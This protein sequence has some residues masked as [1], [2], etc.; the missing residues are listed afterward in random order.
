MKVLL[1]IKPEFVHKIISGNKKF[2]YRKQIFKKDVDTVVIYST[3]PEGKIV[4][5]FKIEKIIK[6]PPEK[7]WD[8]TK[9]CSGITK[10]FFME[11]FKNRQFGYALEISEYKNYDTPIDPRNK[12]NNFTAPQSFKYIDEVFV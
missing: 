7:L 5:E 4:G 8:I 10:Q 9:E 12:F 3:M 6:E 2:E 11:Y 1:S